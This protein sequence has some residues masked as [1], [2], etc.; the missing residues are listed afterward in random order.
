MNISKVAENI[1]ELLK[2]AE[3]IGIG[4]TRKV[5]RCEDIVIK[6]FYIQSGM[7]KVKMNLK[8]TSP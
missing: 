7:P 4:S 1:E 5:Y 3:M 2:Q 6:T 8:C